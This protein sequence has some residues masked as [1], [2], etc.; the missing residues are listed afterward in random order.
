MYKEKRVKNIP[1]GIMTGTLVGA[2]LILAGIFLITILLLTERLQIDNTGLVVM[3]ITLVAALAGSFT[4]AMT[5]RSNLLLVTV[6]TGGALLLILLA[7]T[8]VFFEGQ[9][10]GFPATLALVMGSSLA[11]ALISTRIL[12]KQKKYHKKR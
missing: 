2:V 10:A 6:S 12:N 3:S 4:S 7:I 11:A 1:T 8:A 5:T 9:F